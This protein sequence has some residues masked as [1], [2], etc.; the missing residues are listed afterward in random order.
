MLWFCR[1]FA[2]V[3]L[4]GLFTSPAA[5]GP[6]RAIDELVRTDRA[7]LDALFADGTV[8]E[9]PS[10]FV[11]GRVIPDAGS[12]HTVRR[13]KLIGVLWKGKVFSDGQMINR[14]A[15]GRE[16]VIAQMYVGQSVFDG[17]PA[18]ILDYSGTRLFSTARDEF[19]EIAPG[20]WVGVTYVL[21][22]T[23]PRVVTHFAL[24]ANR[25]CR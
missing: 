25:C 8:G 11:P 21:E 19:R 7:T 1:L 12:R 5:A 6:P 4:C 10:G 17:R 22:C 14:L 13:S 3:G 24:E 9:I 16:A 20:L 23:G 2:V 18:I 15:G